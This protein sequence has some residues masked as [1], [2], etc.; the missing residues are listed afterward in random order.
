MR[1]TDLV[2]A[3]AAAATAVLWAAAN[4]PS[5]PLPPGMPAEHAWHNREIGTRVLFGSCNKVSCA[6]DD[7]L[8]APSWGATP[9]STSSRG[10]CVSAEDAGAIWPAIHARAEGAAAWVWHGDAV[11]ADVRLSISD[12]LARPGGLFKDGWKPN[13]FEGASPARIAAHLALLKADPNYAA[14]RESGIAILGVW[15]DHD[16]GMNDG[17]RDYEHRAESQQ[18][19]SPRSVRFNAVEGVAQLGRVGAVRESRAVQRD[20]RPA[21]RDRGM[22][23]GLRSCPPPPTPLLQAFLNFLD[24]V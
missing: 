10:G 1:F 13:P 23:A 4:R 11:Y 9:E 7:A 24:E 5:P 20:S 2:T 16:Y 12:S 19:G 22:S 14:L 17:G 8:D 15:D 6:E 21:A 3:V 18:V